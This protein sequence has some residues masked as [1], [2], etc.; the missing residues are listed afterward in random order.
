MKES[1]IK[2]GVTIIFVGSIAYLF[3]TF[4][5]DGAYVTLTSAAKD[6]Y[7]NS[8]LVR[9]YEETRLATFTKNIGLFIAL[10]GI[11][12]SFYGMGQ[13]TTPAPLPPRKVLPLLEEHPAQESSQ[14]YPPQRF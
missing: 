7:D 9:S 4:A 8:L 6:L 11:A 10:V 5:E 13:D 3:G 14:Q 1:V 12:I 2:L